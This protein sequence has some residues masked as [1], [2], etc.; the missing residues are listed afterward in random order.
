MNWMALLFLIAAALF[1]WLGF[2]TVKNNPT[3]FTKESFGKT[4]QVLGVLAL[5][6]IAFIAVLVMLLKQ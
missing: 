2:R 4:V 5:A 1:A 3:M 6:L